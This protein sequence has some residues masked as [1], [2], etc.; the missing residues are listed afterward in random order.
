M[1]TFI[2]ILISAAVL[3]LLSFKP[4]YINKHFI[5]VD[6]NGNDP[7][8]QVKEA[9]EGQVSAWNAG[10]L[11][12]AMSFYWNS[13]QMLWI[14]R[15]GIEKGY[16]PVLISFRKDFPDKEK[17]GFYSYH[18]LQ[19]DSLSKEVVYYVFRWKIE[20]NGKR[21]MGGVSSQVWKKI[22]GKWVITSEHGS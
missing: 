17:M 12:K 8:T 18:P 1:K 10:N 15:A 5:C 22:E 4:Q 19:I 2:T 14:S 21:I 7:V 13:D 3:F 16:E 20:L 11:E 9:L 6:T